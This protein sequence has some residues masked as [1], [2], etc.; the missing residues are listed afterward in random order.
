MRFSRTSA[1]ICALATASVVAALVYTG[2]GKST[3]TSEATS[4]LSLAF[5]SGLSVASLTAN[6]STAATA[7]SRVLPNASVGGG[8]FNP[9]ASF[10][11]KKELIEK[12]LN[13]TTAEDCQIKLPPPNDMGRPNCYGPQ[14]YVKVGGTLRGNN[15]GQPLPGGD[16]GLWTAE[17]ADGQACAAATLNASVKGVSSK[18]D[19]AMILGASMLCVMK[20]EGKELPALDSTVDLTESLKTTVQAKNANATVATATI[21]RRPDSPDGNAVYQYA[22]TV[23]VPT[24]S[25]GTITSTINLKHIPRS[26]DNSAYQGRVWATVSGMTNSPSPEFAY[27]VIYDKTASALNYKV[28]SARYP[29]NATDVFDEKGNLKVNGPWEGDITQGIFNLDPSTGTGR[30]SFAWQAGT[31]DSHSR[32]FNVYTAEESGTLSGCGF[33]GFGANFNKT[34]GT[35]ADNAIDR[36]I[37]YWAGGSHTGISNLAQKQCMTQNASGTFALDSARSNITYAPVD[38]CKDTVGNVTVS[39]DNATYSAAATNFDLV[40]LTT[41]PDYATYKTSVPAAP[42]DF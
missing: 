11:K 9:E 25:A 22:I 5:P 31:N 40:D 1:N 17:E 14:L 12:L 13:G 4:S 3:S 19:Q 27:S 42:A 18:V 29:A 16:L 6:T 32:V 8:E 26:T 34:T 28:V 33:F 41:D 37:C 38:S 35:S 36:F 23:T 30:A 15:G 10:K 7:T 2:C 24:P 21:T 39:T 20:V